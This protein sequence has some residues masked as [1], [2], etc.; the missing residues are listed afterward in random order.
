[1]IELA[2]NSITSC[3]FLRS[4]IYQL[5]SLKPNS[6]KG[7]QQYQKYAPISLKFIV[8][9]LLI[10]QCQY[11]ILLDCKLKHYGILSSRCTPNTLRAFQQYQECVYGGHLIFGRCQ[12]DKKTNKQNKGCVT[13]GPCHL[14]VK[15]S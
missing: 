9:I 6:L 8:W 10:F 4:K 3:L 2:Q 12:C 13:L 7:F 15:V 11:S 5:A 14:H 1:M